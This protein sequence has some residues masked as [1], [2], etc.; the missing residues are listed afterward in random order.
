[1]YDTGW[2]PQGVHGPPRT[3]LEGDGL[4]QRLERPQ[5]IIVRL[6]NAKQSASEKAASKQWCRTRAPYQQRLRAQDVG[7][8]E[9]VTG[10]VGSVGK[11]ERVLRILWA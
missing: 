4:L 8:V 10:G 5:K 11:H 1:M 9:R 2:M 7:R 3:W 6:Q